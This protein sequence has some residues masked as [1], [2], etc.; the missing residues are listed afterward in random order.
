MLDD[1]IFVRHNICSESGIK[2]IAGF[3]N[4]AFL[5]RAMNAED[6]VLILAAYCVYISYEEIYNTFPVRSVMIESHAV[7]SLLKKKLLMKC[8]VSPSRGVTRAFFRI[9]EAG[10][11]E[12]SSLCYGNIPNKYP[13]KKAFKNSATKERFTDHVYYSGYNLFSV[14]AMGLPFA[15]RRE[16][17][18]TYGRGYSGPYKKGALIVDA[19]CSFYPDDADRYRLAYF[20]QDMGTESLDELF[21]KLDRYYRYHL[22]DMTRDM[23]VFSFVDKSAGSPVRFASLKDYAFSI[24]HC[25]ELLYYMDENG[26]EDAAD[27]SGDDKVDQEYLKSIM[28]ITGAAIADHGRFVRGDFII[29]SY[30]VREFYDSLRFRRNPYQH[31]EFNLKHASLAFKRMSDMGVHLLSRLKALPLFARELAAGFPVYCI[32]TTLV[33]D[34]LPFGMMNEFPDVQQKLIKSF[35]SYFKDVTFKGELAERLTISDN[36]FFI[37][38]RNIFSYSCGEGKKGLIAAEFM[39]FDLGAWIRAF[40]FVNYM[41]SAYDMPV[42]LI[43]IFDTVPQSRRFF[44]LFKKFPD[45]LGINGSRSGLY[46]LMMKDVGEVNKVFIP[47]MGK[48]G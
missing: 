38:P 27:M 9:T 16:Y 37:R 31:R 18:Y 35:S 47:V 13:K 1:D 7:P 23:I 3:L 42:Q 21:S 8:P 12:A 10:F 40:L 28:L 45:Q 34:R 11:A 14:L 32:P 43:C 17:P 6:I 26:I 15:W 20:E 25:K 22:M 24:A 4:K 19:R 29:D 30:D 48:K 36:G 2:E 44:D 39:S 5:S 33:S 46:G 41:E